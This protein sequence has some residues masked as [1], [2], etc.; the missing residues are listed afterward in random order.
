V[1]DLPALW[2]GIEALDNLVP[3]AVQ[4]EMLLDIVG[5]IEHGAA[6][7]LR[8]NRL[9]IGRETARFAPAVQHLAT[10]VAELLPAGERALL[11]R[12]AARLVAAGAPPDLAS[13][14]AGVIFLTTGFEVGDLAERTGRPIERAAQTFYGVGAH[15]ALDEMRAAARRLPA[16]T[17][18]QKAASETL[19]DDFYAVQAEFAARVLAGTASGADAAADPLEAWLKGNAGRLAPAEAVAAELRIAGTPDLAMLVVASRQL[20]QALV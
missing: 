20:R 11:D 3:A 16:E 12:R 9:D 4:T 8:G 7:L 2:A 17:V 19:I 10:V 15:F 18:Y 5:V 13:R 14:V 6:W 1:F